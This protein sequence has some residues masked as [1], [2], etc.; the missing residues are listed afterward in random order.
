MD[1]INKKSSNIK[2]TKPHVKN[3]LGY[4]FDNFDKVL[5]ENN[6]VVSGQK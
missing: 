4:V 3:P 1:F 6:F 2:T 5:K